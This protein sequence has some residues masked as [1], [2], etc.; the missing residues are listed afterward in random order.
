MNHVHTATTATSFVDCMFDDGF[1]LQNDWLAADA[2]S[3]RTGVLHTWGRGHRETFAR[4]ENG[5]LWFSIA[6]RYAVLLQ[7]SYDKYCEYL[8]TITAS[9]LP[10]YWSGKAFKLETPFCVFSDASSSADTA[11]RDPRHPGGDGLQYDRGRLREEN[12]PVPRTG[13]CRGKRDVHEPGLGLSCAPS[14][15]LMNPVHTTTT[16]AT[17]LP[18]TTSVPVFR[19]PYPPPL[20]LLFP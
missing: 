16:T 13:R 15:S 20:T 3:H 2:C 18:H 12:E 9:T 8:K 7:L 14:A 5:T 11:T 17:Y 10:A 4:Y 19:E 1:I 6:Q